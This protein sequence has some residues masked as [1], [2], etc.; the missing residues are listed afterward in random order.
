M[1]SYEKGKYRKLESIIGKYG[2]ILREFTAAV[3]VYSQV[4]EII[5]NHHTENQITQ[6]LEDPHWHEVESMLQI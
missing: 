5:Y 2:S 4:N 3:S 6:F 1:S